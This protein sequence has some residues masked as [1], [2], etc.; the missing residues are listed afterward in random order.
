MST[1]D[2]RDRALEHLLRQQA[3]PAPE[4]PCPDANALAAWLDGALTSEEAG[5]LE[6]HASTCARCSETM[7]VMMRGTEDEGTTAPQDATP[8]PAAKPRPR[9]M[10]RWLAPLTAAAAATLVWMLAP[11][12]NPAVLE[13]TPDSLQAR[14]EFDAPAVPVPAEPTAPLPSTTP[15]TPPAPAVTEPGRPTAESA[16]LPAAPAPAPSLAGEPAP[17][18]AA[19]PLAARQKAA[20]EASTAAAGDT[21]AAA[22]PSPPE[23]DVLAPQPPA[24]ARAAE[25]LAAPAPTP[26]AVHVITSSDAAVQWRFAG[27]RAVERST[28]EGATWT[29]MDTGA[30]ADLTAGAAPSA[31]ICW[32]TTADGQV[33]RTVDG[34]TWQAVTRP[35]TEVLVS[36]EAANAQNASVTTA[37]GR[38]YITDDGGVTW[39]PRP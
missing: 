29:R 30:T 36:V 13:Q 20:P 10:T 12:E 39:R 35:T 16:P 14:A 2:P 5:V 26:G 24:Q 6:A 21:A 33:L 15:A 32:V 22:V 28:D 17:A 3:P 18:Q 23:L 25:A 9:G 8:A 1:P 38:V 34:T 31:G 27:T 7:A 19:S 37:S 11:R 4:S